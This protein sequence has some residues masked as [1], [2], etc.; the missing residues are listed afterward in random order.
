MRASTLLVASLAIMMILMT[1]DTDAQDIRLIVRGDDLGM[2]QGS[3][4][5]FEK[6]FNEGIL[7]CASIIVPAPWFEAATD[8]IRNNPSWCIGVHLTLI[9]EW[10]GYRW[11]PILPW[12]MVKSIVDEDGFLYTYPGE[13]LAR[14]PRIE[15]IEAEWRAQINLAL[16]K[17]I[18]LQ[19]LDF[20]YMGPAS[21]PGLSDVV[22]KIAIDYN[23]PLSGTLGEKRLPGIY[24]TPIGKKTDLAV[25]TLENLKRGLWLWVFHPGIDSP[26][27]N[28]L[29]HTNPEDVFKDGGVGKH[30]AAET[31][32]LYNPQVKAVIQKRGINLTTY[33]AIWKGLHDRN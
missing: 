26:E 11:R 29:I 19:Y 7:T 28:A 20:H 15:E 30:R 3:L 23:L 5:A 33:G 1:S 27:H 9:G 25:K 31:V 12:N 2:T 32:T 24:K 10:R 18:K 14:T 21:Y 13:L 16:K 4:V 22:Q 6:A 17:G 8:L